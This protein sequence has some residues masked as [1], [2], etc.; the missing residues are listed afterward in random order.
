[1]D[2]STGHYTEPRQHLELCS[3]QFHL[4]DSSRKGL[5]IGR[6]SRFVAAQGW[7]WKWGLAGRAVLLG[8]DGDVLRLHCG[9]G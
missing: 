7:G 6:E 1:M 3:V 5:I 8:G 2:E 9:T 4:Y